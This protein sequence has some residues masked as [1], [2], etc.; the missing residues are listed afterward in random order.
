MIVV[1]PAFCHNR[2]PI[3][4]P[5]LFRNDRSLTS[6]DRD[7]LH[8]HILVRTILAIPRHLRNLV[9]DVLPFDYFTKDRVFAGKPFRPGNSNEK[10]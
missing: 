10:L 7:R 5:A 1:I 6:F 9:D 4:L 8:N 3:T 2:L